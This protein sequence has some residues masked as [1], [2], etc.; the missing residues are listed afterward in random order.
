MLYVLVVITIFTNSAGIA[1]DT[2]FQEFGSKQA[3][4]TAKNTLEKGVYATK[5]EFGREVFA[6]CFAKG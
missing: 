1:T 4:L 2:R 6:D 3:C 5:G